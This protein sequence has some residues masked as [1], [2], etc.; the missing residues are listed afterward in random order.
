MKVLNLRLLVLVFIL[1]IV[2]A[3][4]SI[5][6]LIGPSGWN[7]DN[8]NGF[9]ANSALPGIETSVSTLDFDGDWIYT[10]IGRESGHTNDIDQSVKAGDGSL[11]TS[12]TFSTNNTSNWGEWE[13]VDFDMENLFFEDSDGP[14]NIG[15]DSFGANNSDG[16]RLFRL[17]ENT[18]LN[19][20]TGN[21]NL[22]LFVGDI[23]VGFN[24]NHK[25]NSDGDYD[26]IIIAMRAISV[27]APGSLAL[28]GVGLF[29]LV[30]IRRRTL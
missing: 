11:D 23:I 4:N 7:G 20:L 26:D 28:F 12:L 16:F 15:L 27:P 10:A 22:S 5:A 17:T 19:Y 30:I 25:Y 24:D 14:W 21:S 29:G 2:F 3:H 6:G 8:I 1:Q 9:L 18:T 13:T